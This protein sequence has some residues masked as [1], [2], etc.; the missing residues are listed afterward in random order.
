LGDAWSRSLPFNERQTSLNNAQ[1]KVD[2]DG[3]IRVVISKKDPGVANWLDTT[4]RHEGTI[5]FRNYRAKQGVVPRVRKVKFDEV[6][7][8]LPAGTQLVTPA[9]RQAALE[10]R[11]QAVLKLYGE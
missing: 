10:H 5:V 11:R 6:R 2:A 1:M 3:G 9:E 7:A 4:G 8:D